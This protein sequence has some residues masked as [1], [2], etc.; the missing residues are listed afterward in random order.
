MD[1]RFE[2][3]NQCHSN[4]KLTNSRPPSALGD[5]P[6]RLEPNRVIAEGRERVSN[7][8]TGCKS[9]PL[10]CF[11]GLHFAILRSYSPHCDY[12]R[13]GNRTPQNLTEPTEQR[14]DLRSGRINCAPPYCKKR[15]PHSLLQV[16]WRAWDVGPTV[17]G[18][19]FKSFE[20]F[21]RPVLPIGFSPPTRF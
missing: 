7:P 15:L 4:R 6:H 2:T 21:P 12:S 17:R 18:S 13:I 14:F 16:C 3:Q 9:L 10:T 20:K 5:P 19:G 8:S 11:R 1:C